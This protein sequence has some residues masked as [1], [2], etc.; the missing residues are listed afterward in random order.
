MSY[1]YIGW[2]FNN[3]QGILFERATK[4]SCPEASEELQ[5][6]KAGGGFLV[7]GGLLPN[8][9]MMRFNLL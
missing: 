5:S 6:E 9:S 7:P 4:K 1:S 3:K 8:L 2:L